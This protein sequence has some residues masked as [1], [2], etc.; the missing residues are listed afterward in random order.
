[1][2]KLESVMQKV[3]DFREI[4][5]EVVSNAC[6]GALLAKGFIVDETQIEPG[7]LVEILEGTT[8]KVFVC[9]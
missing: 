7:I 4:A 5:K 1:M 8:A 9:R 3:W 6:Y 2:A